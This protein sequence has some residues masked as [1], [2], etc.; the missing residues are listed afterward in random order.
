M[1][2]EKKKKTGEDL[3]RE[4]YRKSQEEL[5][6]SL[7]AAR[8]DITK[9]FEILD[10][11]DFD[12][13]RYEVIYNAAVELSRRSEP[14]EAYGVAK[15][16]EESGNLHLVDGL[17]GLHQLTTLGKRKQL[18]TPLVLLAKILKEYSARVRIRNIITDSTKDFEG[19]SGS[20]AADSLANLQATLNEQMYKLSNDSTVAEIS[21]L[22]TDYN[23]LLE[24]RRR[25]SEEN[26]ELANGLQGIPSL[27]PSLNKYTSGW[28]PGQMITLAAETGV[29]KSVFAINSAV[30]AM[31][32]AKSVM[33]FSLEMSVE[34]IHDRIVSSISSI[35]MNDLK[36]GILDDTQMRILGET[37]KD[38]KIAKLAIDESEKQTIDSIRAKALKRAQ[39]PEGLDFIIIDYL[40]LITPSGRY[41]SRQEAIA[42]ISRNVKLLAKQLKVPI[43]VLA[44]LNRNKDDSESDMPDL[45]RIRESGAIA[46]D[47]DIVILLHRKKA[48]DEDIPPTYVILE[49]QRN[50][51]SGKIIRCHSQLECSVFREIMSRKES[52]ETYSNEELQELEEQIANEIEDLDDL[53][54][55]EWE[56]FD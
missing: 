17:Q 55:E 21:D 15:V 29:G 25:I 5:V 43:M 34:E 38:L 23:E 37:Q 30:A 39:S 7:L 53:D 20:S 11:Q 52:D 18:E 54:T 27:L 9:V 50:G 56:D 47:S 51:E 33:F 46:Q 6:S 3:A 31:Q 16:L 24:E 19:D 14:V 48:T 13:P 42:D 4:L 12:E 35:P 32:A 26:S 45:S 10:S 8:G 40:Q 41:S 49:K 28:R 22:A 44:Q 36:Q 2:A 1:S